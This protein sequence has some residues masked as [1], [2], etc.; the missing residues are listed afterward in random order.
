M[1]PL[2]GRRSCRDGILCSSGAG[3]WSAIA[4]LLLLFDA[5]L[6]RLYYAFI[7]PFR[8]YIGLSGLCSRSELHEPSQEARAVKSN[9]ALGESSEKQ[10]RSRREHLHFRQ[11]SWTLGS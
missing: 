7:T 3:F 5:P 10:Y 2:K 1:D 8:K 9:T 11:G 6:L 4:P